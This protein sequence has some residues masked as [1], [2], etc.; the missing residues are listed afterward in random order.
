[1]RRYTDLEPDDED[2]DDFDDP[3]DEEDEDD[4]TIPCPYCREQIYEEAEVCPSCGSYISEEDAPR[5][6][7]WWFAVGFLLS[8]LVALYWAF[9]M[10]F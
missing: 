3:W 7:P 6:F 5:R 8:M 2:E 10:W 1:M 9:P 4:D